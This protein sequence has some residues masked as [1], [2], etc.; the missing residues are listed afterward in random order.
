MVLLI[1][2]LP[3]VSLLSLSLKIVMFL[4]VFL[5][6]ALFIFFLR[7]L[8]SVYLYTILKSLLP[9]SF[10]SS[11]SITLFFRTDL[12]VYSSV[13]QSGSRALCFITEGGHK[14]AKS[15]SIFWF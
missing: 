7:L 14:D 9:P 13:V 5:T 2:V 15:V 6:P 8:S 10:I 12:Y 3:F 4:S 1:Y 11:N